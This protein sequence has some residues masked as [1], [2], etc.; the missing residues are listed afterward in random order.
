MDAIERLTQMLDSKDEELE[1]KEQKIED[2]E[3]RLRFG[4]DWMTHQFLPK[5]EDVVPAPCI[6]LELMSEEDESQYSQEWQVTLVMPGR[7]NVTSYIPYSYSKVGR[8]GFDT[9][10]FPVVGKL[11]DRDI[12]ELPSLLNDACFLMEKTGLPAYVILDAETS[13]VYRVTS[14]RPLELEVASPLK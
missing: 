5:E 1:A 7:N 9:N 11:S 10:R 2:L 4:T 13:R 6:A 8:T 14:L 12:N 3:R